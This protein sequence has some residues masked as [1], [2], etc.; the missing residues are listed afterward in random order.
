MDDVEE[1]YEELSDGG[2]KKYFEAEQNYGFS[3]DARGNFEDFVLQSKTKVT[4]I[5][6]YGGTR[7]TYSQNPDFYEFR[8]IKKMPSPEG[9]PPIWVFDKF[10]P[11]IPKH[12]D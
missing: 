9:S 8:V 1:L 2:E 6:F 4:S 10:G 5:N 11:L 7:I 12:K 3:D